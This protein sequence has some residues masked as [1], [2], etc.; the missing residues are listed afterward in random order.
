[1]KILASEMLPKNEIKLLGIFISFYYVTVHG[2]FT[3]NDMI[4]AYDLFCQLAK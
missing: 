4:S 2:P 1:M 3:A